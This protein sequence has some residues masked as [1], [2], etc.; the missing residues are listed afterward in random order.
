MTQPTTILDEETDAEVAPAAETT[1]VGVK[2]FSV[3]IKKTPEGVS[4]DI[5]ARGVEDCNPLASCYAFDNDAV[6]MQEQQD[7][8]DRD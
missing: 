6:F 8:V 2:Q 5:Y 7:E 3:Y 4:V 1:W